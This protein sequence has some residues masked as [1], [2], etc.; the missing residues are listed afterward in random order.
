MTFSM[1]SNKNNPPKNAKISDAYVWFRINQLKLTEF[2][3]CF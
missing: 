1:G 2:N 3:G